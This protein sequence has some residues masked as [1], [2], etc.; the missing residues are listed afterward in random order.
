[1]ARPG[2][3]ASETSRCRCCSSTFRNTTEQT[4]AFDSQHSRIRHAR[5]VL[6]L[7]LHPSWKFVAAL[8]CPGNRCG[9]AST[10]DRSGRNTCKGLFVHDGRCS[11]VGR[12]LPAF[13]HSP[14]W[15]WTHTPV[16]HY[17]RLFGFHISFHVAQIPFSF[18]F[19][20]VR[21]PTFILFQVVVHG[22]PHPGFCAE[23]GVRR[24]ARGW[25]LTPVRPGL[26]ENQGDVQEAFLPN[27]STVRI[28]LARIQ[29]PRRTTF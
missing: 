5:H 6:W 1:M 2:C 14:S 19:I 27:R 26:T 24:I 28:S 23:R 11:S 22:S 16:R 7:L 17:S 13:V 8:F 15:R 12:N 20:E 9:D 4:L 10:D 25:A 3:M 29:F 21:Q 18:Q